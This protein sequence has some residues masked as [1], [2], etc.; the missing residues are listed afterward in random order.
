MLNICG[1]RGTQCQQDSKPSA[2]PRFE[3]IWKD[4]DKFSSQSSSASIL[5]LLLLLF[6]LF[7]FVSLSPL[8]PTQFFIP[9][10]SSHLHPPSAHFFVSPL[11]WSIIGKRKIKLLQLFVFFQRKEKA[12][13]VLQEATS[14]NLKKAKWYLLSSFLPHWLAV[15]L[16][17]SLKRRLVKIG[18]RKSIIKRNQ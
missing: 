11:G 12:C 7:C 13:L 9:P 5:F 1:L 6:I 10:S 4:E 16:E 2:L 15:S 17:R 8:F 18:R 14:R 3:L